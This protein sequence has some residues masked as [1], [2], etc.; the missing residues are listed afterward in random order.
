MVETRSVDVVRMELKSMDSKINLLAQKIKT[1]EKNEEILGRTLVTLNSKIKKLE[2]EV[3]KSNSASSAEVSNEDIER[4]KSEVTS[5]LASKF[6][7]KKELQEVKYTVDLINP[8][9]YASTRQIAEL[10]E[11]KMREVLKKQSQEKK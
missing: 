6:A 2:E 3:D 1:I 9:E 8:L 5:A 4:I 10:V 11:D 7:L